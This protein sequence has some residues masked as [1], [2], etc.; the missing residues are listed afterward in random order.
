M[1]TVAKGP[2]K[3]IM[4]IEVSKIP[5]MEVTIK[6]HKLAKLIDGGELLDENGRLFINVEVG[7]EP[8]HDEAMVFGWNNSRD[9]LKYKKDL[10]SGDIV[11]GTVVSHGRWFVD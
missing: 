5:D 10:K 3:K 11:A 1:V 8:V 7:L 6:E 9:F 2:E 4:C